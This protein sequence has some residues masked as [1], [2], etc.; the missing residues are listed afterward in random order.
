MNII[1][2]LLL[3][4]V[5][6]TVLTN[7][8]A[9]ISYVTGI[10]ISIISTLVVVASILVILFSISE[11][12]IEINS[13]WLLIFASFIV[14]GP[15]LIVALTGELYIRELTLNLFYLLLFMNGYLVYGFRSK[16]FLL[17]ISLL[18]TAFA[19]VISII[20]PR[21]F[22]P[23][24]QLTESRE[25]YWGRAFGLYLQPNSLAFSTLLILLSLY[26]IHKNSSNLLLYFVSMSSMVV[27]LSGSRTSYFCLLIIGL[28]LIYG[29]AKNRE[30]NLKLYLSKFFLVLSTLLFTVIVY[31]NSSDTFQDSDLLNRVNIVSEVF[32]GK[33]LDVDNDKS[34]ISRE[35]KQE[36]FVK[37]IKLS[38]LIGY[39]FGAQQY[40]SF[41]GSS[42]NTYMDVMF[43]GGIVYLIIYLLF[44]L[45]VFFKAKRARVN[46]SYKTPIY[47]L[48]FIILFYGFFSNTVIQSRPLYFVSGFLISYLVHSISIRKDNN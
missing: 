4:F 25:G 5:T 23:L 9:L 26:V 33:F 27:L 34:I 42:H 3:I 38:P 44:I 11:F 30:I 8:Y 1:R 24:M 43:Q 15:M 22:L 19:A 31:F 41:D 29:E 20:E 13:R 48:L 45:A 21:L 47:S 2:N 36:P 10:S 28:I 32:E 40:T 17:N 12:K 46:L 16:K 18:I 14:A 35:K 39:G 7:S 37:A 6:I